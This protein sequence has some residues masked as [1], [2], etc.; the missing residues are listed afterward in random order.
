MLVQEEDWDQAVEADGRVRPGAWVTELTKLT[1]LRTWPAG[2]RLICRRERPHPGAQLSLF[3]TA[4]GFRHT[5]FLTSSKGMP[6]PLELRQRRHARVEDRIRCTK[7]S[8]LRNLPFEDFVRNEAWLATVMVAADLLA[9]TAMLCLEGAMAKAEPAT[10]RY[11]LLHVA[12]RI[13][14]RGRDV[15]LR[16]DETWPWR[17]QLDAAF[18]RLRT[19]LC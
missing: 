8:G 7:A 19:A 13:A 12:A 15:Y 9:W 5:C 3:D 4:E 18:G 14:R 11:Q 1:D 16:I 6:P 2:V 10:L 17:D